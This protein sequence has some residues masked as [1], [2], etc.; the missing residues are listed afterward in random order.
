MVSLF[1]LLNHLDLEPKEDTEPIEERSEKDP[2][3]ET[4]PIE[5]RSD[6][7][8]RLDTEPREERSD[9]DPWLDISDSVDNL[10]DLKPYE[11]KY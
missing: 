6:K 7:D 5:E 3:L 8:P 11:K 2:R 4:E 10:E 9:R 1:K